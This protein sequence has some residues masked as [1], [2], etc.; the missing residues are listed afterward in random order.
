M[1][2]RKSEYFLE[3][4]ALWLIIPLGFYFFI[5]GSWLFSFTSPDEGRNAAAT[6]HMLKTKNFIE[7]Y[8]NCLPRFEKPPML[9][10]SASLSSIFFGFNEFSARLVSGLSAI[11]VV[12]L[13][14]LIGKIISNRESALKGA[15][16]LLSVPHMW[17]ESRAFVPEMLNTFFILLGLY[18]WLLNKFLIGWAFIGFSMVTKG[19]VGPLLATGIYFILRKDLKILKPRG[20]AIFLLVSIW[21]YVAMVYSFG[22]EYLYR[23]FLFENLMRFT[24][25]REV[26]PAPVYYYLIV[27]ALA[28]VWFLPAL[29]SFGK[30]RDGLF[31]LLLWAIFVV[32]FFT[33]AQN[34]LHHYILPSYPAIALIIGLS[35]SWDYLKRVL[36]YSGLLLGF[37]ILLLPK[38]ENLR[39]TKLVRE[40]LAGENSEIYFY[41]SENS[42]V[43]FYLS[44]CIKS[45]ENP[46][47]LVITKSKELEKSCRLKLRGREFDGVYYLFE[48]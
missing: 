35:I 8:Y 25:A 36:V 38:V 21:W 17:I 19:P 4:L 27:L 30:N 16:V 31:S 46:S 40:S 41:K 3:R 13:T 10:W 18:L 24:G 12:F 45:V 2:S 39:F 20:I 1:D 5:F 28:F 43:V 6:I 9:Y 23:F 29:K 48:C 14:F 44:R 32:G 22:F 37:M 42:A 15:L 7:P 11:G 33:I 47:G 26:H 34:R